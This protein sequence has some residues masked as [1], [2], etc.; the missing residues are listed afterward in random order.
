MT[1]KLGTVT[2]LVPGSPEAWKP[3]SQEA[4][5]PGSPEAWKLQ[6]PKAPKLGSFSLTKLHFTKLGSSVYSDGA[7]LLKYDLLTLLCRFTEFLNK[8]LVLAFD[9]LVISYY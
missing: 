4:R 3:G 1:W 5:K 7:S 6:S 9:R 2:E 8:A